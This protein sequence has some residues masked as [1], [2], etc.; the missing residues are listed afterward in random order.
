M[1]PATA[2]SADGPQN[3]SDAVS[4]ARHSDASGVCAVL[5]GSVFH[6]EDLRKTHT[7]RIDA[8]DSGDAGPVARVEQSRLRIFRPWPS[9]E[10]L[11]L[12]AV[13]QDPSSWPR[14]EIVMNHAGADGRIV[15]ALLAQGLAGLVIAGTGN[16]TLSAALEQA[17]RRAQAQGV[18]VLRASRCAHGPVIAAG[19]DDALPA[20]GGLSP[21]QARVALLLDLLAAR[22]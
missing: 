8:F 14:V 1:R 4:V 18:R 9:G 10:A 21:A 19:S 20:S 17:V 5:A 15:D 12:Q 11:G 13:A 6:P 16:G 22:A 2:L 3:L 7:Y